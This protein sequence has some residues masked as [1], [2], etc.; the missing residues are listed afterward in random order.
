MMTL[1][2]ESA[3]DLG[4]LLPKGEQFARENGHKGV[5]ATFTLGVA[6]RFKEMTLRIRDQ[7]MERFFRGANNESLIT[8]KIILHGDPARAIA[9]FAHE[10]GVD[11]IVMG[12]HRRRPVSRLLFGSV[13]GRVA[14]LAP[15]PVLAVKRE[16]RGS[17]IAPVG[18]PSNGRLG[19]ALYLVPPR[20][21]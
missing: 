3:T 15:C 12:T 17:R 7:L 10:A 14:R 16:E 19:P 5:A 1:M 2:A 11:I 4:E 8:Q 21:S 20:T 18:V 13:A 6:D 9:R